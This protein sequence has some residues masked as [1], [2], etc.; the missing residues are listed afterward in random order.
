MG[1]LCG[2]IRQALRTP[3]NPSGS[4]QSPLPA[5][6]ALSNANDGE[7]RTIGS[8]LADVGSDLAETSTQTPAPDIRSARLP[9]EV[10]AYLTSF[11]VLR[12]R[13]TT[14]RFSQSLRAKRQELSSK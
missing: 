7:A 13:S 14:S 9:I 8:E 10:M 12:V 1:I 6:R 5:T 3:R 11:A 4:A 2:K